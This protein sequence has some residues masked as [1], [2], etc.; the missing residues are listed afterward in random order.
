MKLNEM[1]ASCRMCGKELKAD[2]KDDMFVSFYCV[3]YPAL[4][5]G[6]CN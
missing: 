6:A 1:R 5:D 3:N 2:D 4:K